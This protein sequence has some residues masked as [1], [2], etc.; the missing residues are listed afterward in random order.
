MKR[1][2][3]LATLALGACSAPQAVQL[4][5]PQTRQIVECRADPWAVRA[6]DTARWN[7]ECAQ[8]YERNGFERIK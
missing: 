8:K 2:T 3:I 4:R 5:D 7:E 1:L 6:W